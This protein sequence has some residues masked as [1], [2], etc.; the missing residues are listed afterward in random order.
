MRL[1]AIALLLPAAGAMAQSMEPRAYSNLPIGLNIALVGYVY[2]RGELAFDNAVPLD[3]GES[4][5]HAMPLGYVRSLDILGKAGSIGVAVPLVHL[6]ATATSDGNEVGRNVTGLG[7]PALRLAWNFYGAPAL[8]AK[9]FSSYRQD[10]IVGTSLTVTAP[11]GQYDADR[12]VNIGTNRWSFKPELGMSQALGPWTVELAGG[13]T[14]YTRNDDYFGGNSRS[15]EPVY[16][17]QLHV[18]RQLGRGA[19]AAVSGTYY[20]GGR[21][22]IN[23]VEKDD[24][25]AASRFAATLALPVDR[26][27]SIKLVAASGVYA[28]TGTDYNSLGAFWQHLWGD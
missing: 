17:T 14:F 6:T 5:V 26:Q 27:N 8:S 28:T 12:L 16:S 11:F 19:W 10:L 2:S 18:T 4:R 24:R 15:Q 9:E 3:N 20:A 25:I 13:V 21:S 22:S 1:L 7:D 23:G